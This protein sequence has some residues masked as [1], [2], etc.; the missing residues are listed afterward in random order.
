MSVPTFGKLAS[1]LG[2]V[3]TPTQATPFRVALLGDFSGRA[4]RG[5]Q[6]DSRDLAA[7]KLH[8]I[9]RGNSEEVMEK[10]GVALNLTVEDETTALT[11][12][13]LDDFHPDKLVP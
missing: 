3:P 2:P 13:S 10:L 4:N 7:R 5:R 6:G 9:D 12:A 11:F 8:K 1:S